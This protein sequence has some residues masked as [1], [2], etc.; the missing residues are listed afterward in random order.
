M[1]VSSSSMRSA[2]YRDLVEF[3]HGS[4]Y[5][6]GVERQF[7]DVTAE[8]DPA[9]RRLLHE[10]LSFVD[11]LELGLCFGLLD[12]ANSDA[13]EA[14]GE[15]LL[16]FW[17]RGLVPTERTLA[18]HHLMRRAGVEGLWSTEFGLAHYTALIDVLVKRYSEPLATYVIRV[19]EEKSN[20][21]VFGDIGVDE[22]AEEFMDPRRYSD[23]DGLH[24]M[25]AACASLRDLDY[26][27]FEEDSL[28]AG[29]VQVAARGLFPHRTTVFERDLTEMFAALMEAGILS[30]RGA[31][32]GSIYRTAVGFSR[33]IVG[34]LGDREPGA[35]VRSWR[36]YVAG[37]LADSGLLRRLGSKPRGLRAPNE[38][39]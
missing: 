4:R 30:W 16:E 36:E 6:T 18:A 23:V 10:F 24:A 29:A 9:F 27:R 11:F 25:V 39:R 15:R 2:N 26:H 32:L 33:V 12:T 17:D 19:A 13:Y 20:S 3:H 34:Q 21:L 28:A 8:D 5:A 14:A 1:T 38:F 31:G 7:S 22:I 35:A 37:R